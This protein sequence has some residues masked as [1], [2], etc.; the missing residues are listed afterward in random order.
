MECSTTSVAALTLDSNSHIKS[1][2]FSSLTLS[3]LLI[4]IAIQNR[5]IFVKASPPYPLYYRYFLHLLQAFDQLPRLI[6]FAFR[7]SMRSEVRR[8]TF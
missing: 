6:P 1:V 7:S 8:A 3:T 2:L 4:V 5:I